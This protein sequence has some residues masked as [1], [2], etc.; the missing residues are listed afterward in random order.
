MAPPPLP[1]PQTVPNGVVGTVTASAPTTVA[2]SLSTITPDVIFAAQAGSSTHALFVGSNSHGKPTVVI[3]P[4]G[5]IH[6]ILV[7]FDGVTKIGM[8]DAFRVDTRCYNLWDVFETLPGSEQK[9]RYLHVDPKYTNLIASY[10]ASVDMHTTNFPGYADLTLKE[11][12]DQMCDD[13]TREFM[14]KH[15]SDK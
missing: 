11:F 10:M 3:T 14:Q 12:L 9:G 1:S 15:F 2:A 7:R 6:R 4:E 13:E 5:D 8:L